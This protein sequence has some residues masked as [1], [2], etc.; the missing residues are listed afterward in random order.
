M[1]YFPLIL[2]NTSKV[3]KIDVSLS[4]FIN[5]S[6]LAEFI[7]EWLNIPTLSSHALP[8]VISEGPASYFAIYK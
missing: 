5:Q 1:Q 4:W 8:T 6:Y 3:V 7:F 2:T